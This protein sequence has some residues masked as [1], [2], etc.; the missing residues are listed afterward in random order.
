MNKKI[1]TIIIALAAICGCQK[2]EKTIYK[3]PLSEH[4]MELKRQERAYNDS[5]EKYSALLDTAK[6]QYY[7]DLHKAVLDTLSVVM[8]QEAEAFMAAKDKEAANEEN[9]SMTTEL[10]LLGVT[11]IL[12]IATIIYVSITT[13]FWTRIGWFFEDAWHW[14]KRRRIIRRL[15]IPNYLTPA[16]DSCFGEEDLTDEGHPRNHEHHPRRQ[17]PEVQDS[18]AGRYDRGEE[19]ITPHVVSMMCPSRSPSRDGRR[20]LLNPMEIHIEGNLQHNRYD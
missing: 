3:V 17:S 6:T 4:A 13:L 20:V 18:E 7:F 11:I 2:T 19:R 1:I 5:L 15:F 12:L 8:Q 14:L 16:N 10:I 9:S